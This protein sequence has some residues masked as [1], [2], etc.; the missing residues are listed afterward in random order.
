M[1]SLIKKDLIVSF[2]NKVTNVMFILFFPFIL[3]L[4]RIEDINQIFMFS[5]FSF[6]FIMTKIPFSYEERDRS[7]IFT[8]SLP[9][10]KGDIVISKYLSIF[11]NFLIGL[12]Y[13]FVYMWLTNIIGIIN[14]DKIPTS[15]IWSTLGFT[16]LALSL[17]T[18]IHF[19]F[20]FKIAN[21]VNIFF[22]II[23]V[24]Y[25]MLSEDLFLKLLNIKFNGNFSK[26]IIVGGIIGIYFISMAVSIGLYKTRKFY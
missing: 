4:S 9:I 16:V 1:L 12:M 23:I 17:S 8:Q 26:L 3:F 20:S 6:A 24:S 2:S 5:T 25:I 14:M 21:F 18:P 7:H 13:T 19:R 22:Y 11:L 10:T 15:I